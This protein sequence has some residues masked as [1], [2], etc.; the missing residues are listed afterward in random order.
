MSV[1]LLEKVAAMNPNCG[2]R[3]WV[4]IALSI[5]LQPD[6]WA[7]DPPAVRIDFQ[8]LSSAFEAGGAQGQKAA[9]I[10]AAQSMTAAAASPTTAVATSAAIGSTV[11]F[12]KD[13][14]GFSTGYSL[15]EPTILRDF[16]LRGGSYDPAAAGVN[17]T[18]GTNSGVYDPDGVPINADVPVAVP[19]AYGVNAGPGFATSSLGQPFPSSGALAY[20]SAAD[21]SLAKG[22]ATSAAAAPALPSFDQA[23]LSALSVRGG[24]L[25]TGKGEQ[26]GQQYGDMVQAYNKKV[27]EYLQQ[28]VQQAAIADTVR[29]LSPQVLIKARII[30]VGRSNTTDVGTVLDYISRN[31]RSTSHPS[32]FTNL[33][34]TVKQQN[35]DFRANFPVPFGTGPG[36]TLEITSK[37]IDAVITAIENDFKV[38]T[39][40]APQLI[41]L[42]DQVAQFTSGDSIPFFY[43]RNA[44]L[45]SSN[46]TQ[47]I[48]FKNVGVILQVVPHVLTR[49]E[50]VEAFDA[51]SAGTDL[52]S[53]VQTGKI[54]PDQYR[55]ERLFLIDQAAAGQPIVLTIAYRISDPDTTQFST[56]KNAQ[57]IMVNSEQ[58]VRAGTSVV[59]VHNGCGI[60]IS[61]LINEAATD[62][63]LKVPVLGDIPLI[64][65][66]FRR[67]TRSRNKFETLIFIEA[68][69]VGGCDPGLDHYE[70]ADVH[71]P[72]GPAPG[73]PHPPFSQVPLA[74]LQNHDHPA[75]TREE[76]REGFAK[77]VTTAVEIL[78]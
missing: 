73:T 41:A 24:V 62:D 37:R 50:I 26:F 15:R 16:R 42:N 8:Q 53:L 64:G 68:R 56:D 36:A 40:A 12:P 58:A 74:P 60:I 1:G 3:T 43:G 5:A 13:N 69:I 77:P 39:V 20:T 65:N 2:W 33:D 27:T 30:Q 71:L 7:A 9:A 17:L 11:G 47:E 45:D 19:Q 59:R 22:F 57:P 44:T 29:N 49:Q 21:F 32:F 35:F 4:A 23:V 6:L 76:I 75:I 63:E 48:F 14:P 72:G 10:I 18:I 70:Y 46:H 55:A 67:K 31:P 61:G 54:N 28:Q 52:Q 34:G 66:A 38:D 78:K 51:T 25:E